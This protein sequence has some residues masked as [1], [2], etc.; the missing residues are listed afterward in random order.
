MSIGIDL[1]SFERNKKPRSQLILVDAF[2]GE[3][4]C[5]YPVAAEAPFGLSRSQLP[6]GGES[7]P[8]PSAMVF[9]C[10]AGPPKRHFGKASVQHLHP[11]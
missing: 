7:E 9:V 2:D 8:A 6:W 11:S 4:I 10:L 1:N 3:L 5:E